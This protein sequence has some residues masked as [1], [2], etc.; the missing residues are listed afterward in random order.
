MKFTLKRNLF[1]EF[2]R[3]PLVR[4]KNGVRRLEISWPTFELYFNVFYLARPEVQMG[5]KVLL[6]Q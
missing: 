5:N 3:V 4:V 1:L 6:V 2:F